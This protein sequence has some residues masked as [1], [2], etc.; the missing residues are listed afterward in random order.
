MKRIPLR[1]KDGSVRAYALVD[2]EDFE[3][4]SEWNWSLNPQGYAQRTVTMHAEIMGEMSD[5]VDRDGLNNRRGNL[6]PATKA[7]NAQNLSIRCDSSS[8]YRGVKIGR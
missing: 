8:G 2:D 6:R 3:H 1:A 5:H 7:Q 4:L